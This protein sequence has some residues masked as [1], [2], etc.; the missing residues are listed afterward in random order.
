MRYARGRR[1]MAIHVTV[2][3]YQQK[4]SGEIS[5]T[6]LGL[7]PYNHSHR[8][9]SAVKVQ[10]KLVDKLRKA[11]ADADPADLELFQLSRGM[12]LIFPRLELT[13][14]GSQGRLRVSGIFPLVIE[15][16][17][18]NA[19]TRILLVYHPLR[20][21]EWLA[22]EHAGDIQSKATLFFRNAWAE[23]G[24]TEI[25]SLHADAKD[26]L[27]SISFAASPRTLLSKLPSERD[28]EA[29]AGAGHGRDG[30]QVLAKIGVNQTLRAVEGTLPLGMPRPQYRQTMELLLGGQ[31][32]R[33]T[34]V[35][36]PPGSG[37]T[38]VIHRWIADLLIEDQWEVHRDLDRIHNVWT[39]SG[40]RIIAGMSMLGDWEQRCID[41]LV[42]AK[43]KRAILVV[44]DLHLFG[45]LGQTRESDR[46]LAELFRG[47]VSR[48]ELLMIGELTPERLQRL[49][50]DAPSF[51]ALFGRVRVQPTTRGETLQM[52]LHLSRQLEQDTSR[53]FHPFTYRTVLEMGGSLFPWTAFPGKAIDMLRQLSE[54]IEDRGDQG[55]DPQR[56]TIAP[57]DVITLLSRQTGL[58]ENLLTL[59]AKLD[60]RSVRESFESR[61]MGQSVAVQTACD[62][63]F[64]VR[65]GLTDPDRPL[66]VLLFTGPTGTGKTEL[67]RCIA[68]Y[69]FS[70][71]SR[72]LRL[73]MS[74]YASADAAARLI[75][76]RWRPEGQLT[77]RIREQP[78]SVVLFDEI[79]KA[80]PL[81]LNL[82]LQLFDEGRLTDA[83]GNTAS[84]NHA[85]VIM[86]SNLGAKPQRP[87]G[88]GESAERVMG[89]IDRAVRDFFPPELFNRIDKVVP[90]RPLS[91]KV[92]EDIATKELA[93][94]LAR[95]GLKERNIFVYANQ[96][97]KERIVREAFDPA[98]GARTVKRYLEDRIGSLLAEEIT[99]GRRAS[100]RV[101]RVYDSRPEESPRDS[102]GGSPSAKSPDGEGPFRVHVEPLTEMDP[103]DATWRLLPLVE[104]NA[105]G[106]EACLG[107]AAGLLDDLVEREVFARIAERVRASENPNELYYFAD[108]YETRVLWLRQWLRARASQRA[109]R[110]H[111]GS[112][113]TAIGRG[114]R[115]DM[116]RA[117]RPGAT[118]SE[119]FKASKSEL[120]ARIAEAYFLAQHADR[121]TV[122]DEHVAWIEVLR[123]GHGQKAAAMRQTVRGLMAWMT[124]WLIDM[125][126]SAGGPVGSSDPSASREPTDDWLEAAALRYPDGRI[127]HW[128]DGDVGARAK[129]ALSR[130]RQ[131]VQAV[132]KLSGLCVLEALRGEAG[133]HIWRSIAAEPEIVRVRVWSGDP[134]GAV[135]PVIAAHVEALE[136]FERA[137]ERGDPCLPQNP[138]KLM[139][140]VRTLHFRPPMRQGEVFPVEVEDFH[141]DYQASLHVRNIADALLRLWLLRR[142]RT[143]PASP[144]PAHAETGHPGEDEDEDEEDIGS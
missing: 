9:G 94:L 132:L 64:R 91:A 7:G 42:E 1:A 3:I 21:M 15:P 49:E 105:L 84:F 67:A 27:T 112:G 71:T 60:A 136:A 79:E 82:L 107:E 50:D 130:D 127:I 6:T 135:R 16:R 96:A 100:M 20:Q 14:R 125:A 23:L 39:I 93:R 59:E 41:L 51:A 26:S 31:R 81:V 69:L 62:L 32:K 121:V 99:S 117:G 116:A 102:P 113:S 36:G 33:P 12:E 104:Q 85:V 142:S 122:P 87:I 106:I 30:G 45:R 24:E 5:W 13:L 58:P 68:E 138:E 98:H 38:T 143:E 55:G 103:A 139:P 63:V 144:G 35:V 25:Q 43:R 124:D 123:V 56:A 115:S 133:C 52:M 65:A 134:D 120:L 75:G 97:V 95:R 4:R 10:R 83:A 8:G 78:F 37:K 19:D 126:Q 90:F 111:A 108:A 28:K 22:V 34:V 46:N 128:Q 11:L 114:M 47:P 53:W 131:P 18:T 80:H 141:L 61:V 48:G 76:D 73:D 92:A 70:T 89:E 110:E 119:R 17:W 74:E 72:L 2:P 54:Q 40:K 129:E 44:E 57:D 101:M 66:A 86:T 140:A 29:R 118:A 77:Q 137:L 109:K 88:F